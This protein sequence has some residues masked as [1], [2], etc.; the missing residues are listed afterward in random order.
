MLKMP[1]IQTAYMAE[2]IFAE[3]R[4]PKYMVIDHLKKIYFGTLNSII[5]LDEE[6]LN[7]YLEP[8]FAKKLI[9]KI[10]DLKNSGFK[11]ELY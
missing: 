11:L 4:I 1:K 2:R 8:T 7:E 9:Q 6:F 3:Q 5:E 10:K